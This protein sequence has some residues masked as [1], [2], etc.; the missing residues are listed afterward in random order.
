M[1]VPVGITVSG[2]IPQT[3]KLVFA[4]ST[5]VRD[6]ES[7][8]VMLPHEIVVPVEA[9]V[10]WSVVIPS[11]DDPE[12][13]P[14]GWTWEVRPHFPHWKTPFS[15]AIPYDSSDSEIWFSDLA[16]VP[17]DGDGDLYS[18][19]NHT[20]PGGGSGDPIAISDVTG[21]TAALAGKQASGS[22]ADAVHTHTIANVTSL[23][24]ALDGKADDSDITALDTRVDT[25]EANGPFVFAWDGD[26][27][28]FVVGS[29]TY[30]GPVDPGEIADGSTWINTA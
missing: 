1:T 4:S 15:V 13:S 10:E 27:Y 18:L 3:G 23:Q 25:L 14:T 11:T 12:F 29:I 19:A 22:Y 21:L 17:P 28:N 8:A 24:T 16:P 7:N 30:I 2:L 6:G 9:N 5:L 20:H 26:S